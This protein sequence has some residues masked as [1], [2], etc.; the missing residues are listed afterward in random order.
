MKNNYFP[1]GTVIDNWFYDNVT[2]NINNLGVKYYINDYI[3]P[4]NNIN[5]LEIQNLIDRIYNAGGGILVI[6][7]VYKTGAIFLKQGVHLYIEE[8]AEIIGSDDIT[9]YPVLETRIEGE[10]CMYYPA[11]INADNIDGLYIGG[12]GRINGNGLKSWKSF[13]QRRAWNPGCTNKD[14]Q[15]PR[16]LYVSNSKNVMVEGLKLFDSHFWTCHIYKCSKVKFLNLTI[17]SPK[18]PVKAP[19]TDAIDIDVCSDILIKNCYMSVNDDAV[20]LKGGKGPYA[21]SDINNGSNERVLVEDCEFG[22]CHACMT[23]GSESIHN[24][25]ILF[26]NSKSDQANNLLWLKMRPD[27]PQRYEYVTVENITGNAKNIL[28]VKPWTQFFDLKGREDIPLSYADNICLNNLNM[29]CHTYFNVVKRI[30][31]YVLSNFKLINL[32]INAKVNGYTDDLIENVI[33]DNV[34]VCE[35]EYENKANIQSGFKQNKY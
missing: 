17:L 16:L 24:K 26:R 27:T 4:N 12:K 18:E 10:T 22:F 29:L 2:P 14:E 25:N 3:E 7:D 20:V 34:N 31:Q 30:D 19:S 1:D 32:N 9:D 23:L 5:T 8:N 15:R 33:I 35:E 21:D 11:L 6:N 13:W 28:L